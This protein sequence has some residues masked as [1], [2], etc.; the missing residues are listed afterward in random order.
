MANLTVLQIQKLKS[1]DKYQKIPVSKGL[2]IGISTAGEKCFFIRYTVNS[3]QRDYRLPKVFAQTSD[4][5]G[6]SLADARQK[7]AEIQAL[8]KSG[9][10][11]QVKL[12]QDAAESAKAAT[13][14]EIDKSTV[15]DLYTTW[16]PTLRHKD[17]GVVLN[18]YFTKDILPI[19][20][21]IPLKDL[22]ESHITNLIAPVAAL[23]MN[24]K[25]VILLNDLKQMFKWGEGRR[26]WKLLIIDNPVMN[27]KSVNVTQ[28]SYTE[29]ERDRF[30]SVDEIKQ[31]ASKIPQSGLMKHTEIIIWLCLSCAT[32]V[33]ETT[34]AKWENVDLI[35]GVWFIPAEDTKDD[36]P[37]QTVYLSAFAVRK[38]EQL[39]EL[40]LSPVWCFPNRAGN[41]PQVRN[42]ATKQID[43]R[44]AIY[45]DSTALRKGRTQLSS[46]LV[47]SGGKWTPHDLRRTCTTM[48]QSLGIDQNIIE[49]VL[50]HAEPNRMQRIYQRHD[51]K[52]ELK[53]A[54][55]KWGAKLEEVCGV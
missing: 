29:T 6:I 23:G 27:L 10:D 18:R 26:P 42:A 47:V 15:H 5:S 43:D 16:F 36:S 50:N 2:Y 20:G 8:A 17:D 25:A 46:A 41:A 1:S 3:R 22:V 14:L 11:Y 30:L 48:M 35:K 32:R 34:K 53:D 31:L 37:A 38:F 9:V 7:A 52:E 12:E 51:Y 44:Q 55:C 45:R 40:N 49:R 28:P 4:D 19:I 21:S 33:G 39:K 24:R 13:A 54:W